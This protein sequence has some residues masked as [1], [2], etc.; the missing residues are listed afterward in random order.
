MIHPTDADIGRDVLYVPRPGHHE[1]GTITSFND[2]FVF[3]SY[4]GDTH[5][6]AT[7]RA[8]LEWAHVEFDPLERS[9]AKA[10]PSSLAGRI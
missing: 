3:V 8:K 2:Q 10:A 7:P 5:S 1:A 4:R 6:K 9:D